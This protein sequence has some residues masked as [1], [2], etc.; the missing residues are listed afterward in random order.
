MLNLLLQV[1]CETSPG[2]IGTYQVS[3]LV[4][5]TSLDTYCCIG[6]NDGYSPSLMAVRPSAGPP[7]TQVNLIGD[8]TWRIL[9]DC[10]NEAAGPND[11][12]CVGEVVFGD[13]LCDT[14]AGTDDASTVIDI[15]RRMDRFPGYWLYDV[16]CTVPDPSDSQGDMLPGLATAGN[17]N[18]SL[19]FEA[20]LRGGMTAVELDAY[21]GTRKGDSY[22]F[23]L[24]A[25]VDSVSPP[26]GSMAGG[27]ELTLQGRGFPVLSLDIGDTVD[28][29]VAGSRCSVLSSNF[30]HLTC[31][32]GPLPDD[33]V[34]PP[35]IEGVWPGMRGLEMEVYMEAEDSV[36]RSLSNLGLLNDTITVEN[37]GD[38]SFRT[39]ETAIWETPL[40]VTADDDIV[41]WCSKSKAFFIAPVTGDFRF[42]MSV[43]D[44]GTLHGSWIKSGTATVANE[45]LI[46]QHGRSSID[47]YWQRGEEQWSP[48]V[49][50]E[51]N[52]SILLDAAQCANPWGGGHLQLAVLIP[53]DVGTAKSLPEIQKLTVRGDSQA[54]SQVIS[55]LSGTGTEDTVLNVTATTSLEYAWMLVQEYPATL[56]FKPSI[57]GTN[58]GQD[59]NVSIIESEQSV[60]QQLAQALGADT[61][62]IGVLR[63]AD[64]TTVIY[65]IGLEAAKFPGFSLDVEVTTREDPNTGF[66]LAPP[67]DVC[68]APS[69]PLPELPELSP[70]YPP[71]FPPESFLPF[72]PPMYPS[73]YP[74]VYPSTYPPVYPSTYPPVYP[75]TYVPVYPSTYPPVYPWTYDPVYP[76]TY[77]P[78]YPST[79]PPVYPFMDP[80][81][82]PAA[83]PTED[84]PAPLPP[85]ADPRD[86]LQATVAA[87]AVDA[88][89]VLGVDTLATW[90]MGTA[91]AGT[92]EE[93]AYN[94]TRNEVQGAI[95]SLVG[96]GNCISSTEGERVGGYIAHRWTIEWPWDQGNSVPQL[97]LGPGP[98]TPL[99]HRI[100]SELLTNA[101]TPITGLLEV[102]LGENCDTVEL[103]LVEDKPTIIAEKLGRLRGLSGRPLKVWKSGND[104]T[105]YDV[106]V[107]FDPVTTAGNLPMMRVTSLESVTGQTCTTDVH[108]Q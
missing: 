80:P 81:A 11:E 104:R 28:V 41:R 15:N 30:T 58:L 71:P 56:T 76:S 5:G 69:P 108:W 42:Y 92:F 1:V 67:P 75:S 36:D 79:Y 106:T 18:V 59:F 60:R 44:Y 19:H 31:E 97:L 17:V 102:G 6:Y 82:P 89:V 4:D 93:L 103:D 9:R 91:A 27:T 43:H 53:S 10:G 99:G 87:V 55:Y 46:A 32:T 66:Q 98:Q 26:L 72:Y 105:G 62:E 38:K 35:A 51:A 16:S 47:D 64:V 78:I 33:Y 29:E 84:P 54:R 21:Q 63:Y 39:I 70:A 100:T 85:T 107:H 49:Y 61:S 95:R 52:Q 88:D 77:P 23:Q 48:L 22:L 14:G 94:A 57:N 40:N 8:A 7:G 73:A 65:Q 20:S 37:S 24:Y 90:R 25:V 13:Y 68:V 34:P 50:L 12:S 2:D 83:P 101:S 45:L 86:V 96:Y 3:V 74:P